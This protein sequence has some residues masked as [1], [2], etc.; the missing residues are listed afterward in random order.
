LIIKRKLP[1]RKRINPNFTE[2]FFQKKDE[3]GPIQES[4]AMEISRK[5]L[6]RIA[7]SVSSPS[8]A[9]ESCD[10]TR[11]E[12]L[13]QLSDSRVAGW[14]DTLAAKCKAKLDWKEDK[15][16]QEEEQRRLQDAEDAERRRT[17]RMEALDNAGRLLRE[18]TEKVRQFRQ[19]QMLVETLDTRDDQL[20]E[21]VEKRKITTALEELWHKA[22]MDDIQKAEQKSKQE[23]E[24]DKQRSMDLAMDL[25]RQRDE[26]GERIRAQQR[27]KREEE[28]HIIQKIAIDDSSAE[29]VGIKSAPSVIC[30]YKLYQSITLY[31]RLRWS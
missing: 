26:R 2:R 25:R 11:K 8:N 20:K 22:V 4:I 3:P 28:G 5:D 24:K 13:K 6:D 17:S 27:R 16:R 30:L 29:K 15:A 19:Q 10:V 7:S 1:P 9:A 18:Q 23:M 31:F 21:Q 14:T 12:K